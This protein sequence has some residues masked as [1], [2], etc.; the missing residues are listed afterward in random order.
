MACHN[1]RKSRGLLPRNFPHLKLLMLASWNSRRR[2][3]KT[4]IWPKKCATQ[5]LW[6]IHQPANIWQVHFW[7]LEFW[8]LVMFCMLLVNDS[9]KKQY[10]GHFWI[11]MHASQM[12]TMDEWNPNTMR[13]MHCLMGGESITLS[14]QTTL[15]WI[16]TVFYGHMRTSPMLFQN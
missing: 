10:W 12:W 2:H 16:L 11:L 3:L 5:V 13:Q 6:K 4:L 8:T 14:P 1:L 9:T 15:N 7:M